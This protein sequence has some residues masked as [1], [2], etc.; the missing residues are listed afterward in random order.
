MSN[1]MNLEQ[2]NSYTEEYR[3]KYGTNS[4]F[5]RDYQGSLFGDYLYFN[6][7]ILEE[8]TVETIDLSIDDLS[9]DFCWL[10]G[11]TVFSG[12][13]YHDI[14]IFHGFNII[15]PEKICEKYINIMGEHN[16]IIL[17]NNFKDGNSVAIIFEKDIRH[18]NITNL[19]EYILSEKSTI[20]QK[21]SFFAGMRDSSM[22]SE[23]LDIDDVLYPTFRF[24]TQYREM[25]KIMNDI[26][27]IVS[28]EKEKIHGKYGEGPLF[29]I[30]TTDNETKKKFNEYSMI[31]FKINQ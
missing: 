15:L 2:L 27:L 28:Y 3:I 16:H 31:K 12:F 20:E 14:N 24:Y 30:F 7:N 19:K 1:K 17:K 29:R 4:E 9:I 6:Y 21:L 18:K 23:C 26:G 25:A 22:I 11:V 8:T 5:Y 13:F 10:L